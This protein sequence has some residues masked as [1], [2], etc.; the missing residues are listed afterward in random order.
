MIK[1]DD[2]GKRFAIHASCAIDTSTYLTIREHAPDLGGVGETTGWWA[3]SRITS[4]VIAVATLRDALYI[5]GSAPETT[6]R[7]LERLGIPD[8][9]RW[10][11]GPTVYVLADVVALETPVPC[12]GW[13]G[14]WTLAPELEHAVKEQL[15]G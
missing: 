7:S 15:D 3:L 8:Q 4:A 12:R 9:E 1:R 2:F 14:F 10:T 11:F 13:Q 6:R 5:G